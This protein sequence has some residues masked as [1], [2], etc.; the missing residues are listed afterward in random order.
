MGTLTEQQ[1]ER[2][3][4]AIDD[5]ASALGMSEKAIAIILIDADIIDSNW[6]QFTD[7]IT[8]TYEIYDS[9]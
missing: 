3:E 7:T 5:L 9:Y 8:A 4:A 2:A 1:L 6:K